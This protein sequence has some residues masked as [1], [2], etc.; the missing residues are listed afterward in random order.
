MAT[1][2][3]CVGG[4]SIS[5]SAAFSSLPTKPFSAASTFMGSVETPRMVRRSSSLSG[6]SSGR[7]MSLF[8]GVSVASSTEVT[9]GFAAMDGGRD[10]KNP[11]RPSKDFDV[12]K[13]EV[14]C[15][16]SGAMDV[17]DFNSPDSGVLGVT[18]T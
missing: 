7:E 15:G 13:Y 9:D 10:L 11:E 4:V 5:E 6:S 18:E 3:D 17:S 14:G 12:E 1:A 2:V 16:V 8:V